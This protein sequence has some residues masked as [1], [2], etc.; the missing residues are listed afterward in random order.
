M[1]SA[2]LKLFNGLI[3]A[4]VVI[5]AMVIGAVLLFSGVEAEH[6][7]DSQ[8]AQLVT[9]VDTK[10]V[11]ASPRIEATG[12][13]VPARKVTVQPQVSGRVTRRH[14]GLVTGGVV[15]EGEPLLEIDP[16]DYRLALEQAET[17]VELAR[18]DLELERGRQVVAEQEW[19]RFGDAD[20]EPA[21]LALRKP[22]QQQAKLEIQQAEQKLQQARLE[23]ERTRIHAPFTALVQEAE[24]EP[25]ELVSPSTA[26]ARLVA[27]DEF[28][29]QV[30]VPVEALGRL[31]IPGRDGDRG[32][33]AY[34]HYRTGG[35][36][37]E[38]EGRVIRLLG[39]LDAAGR[40]AQ[41]LVSVADP[42]SLS[43]DE[44]EDSDPDTPA[45]RDA[46]LL[47]DS[48]VSVQLLSDDPRPV[49]KLPRL[50]LRNGDQVYIATE[51]DELEVRDVE[52]AWR[53]SDTVAIR[54]GLDDG[55]RI[56]VSG[57]AAPIEG[58][59]LNVEAAPL[60]QFMEI[61]EETDDE[62]LDDE[63]LDDEDADGDSDETGS[64]D[65]MVDEDGDVEDVVPL[66]DESEDVGVDEDDDA[67]DS[68]VDV[69]PARQ[70]DDD[71]DGDDE[72]DPS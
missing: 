32:S 7:R 4:A 21:P 14:P 48:F 15:Q 66:D 27:L 22:Q 64:D 35:E 13:V 38:H 34:I 47:L 19:E 17:A 5:V 25:G 3:A 54:D 53:Q 26:A 56:I 39:D 52:I 6:D 65:V 30:S 61:P 49:I 68:D 70:E 1:K 63:K 11:T 72:E 31:A 59:P 51:D 23:L 67:V 24:I 58:M 2:Q 43:E 36:A 71:D 12:T 44:I 28:W 20:G 57:L 69:E 50:A 45:L 62:E 33:P 18:A 10:T 8:A 41:L 55:T 46:P 9:S 40:T 29:V 60:E 42:F 37:V 16:R